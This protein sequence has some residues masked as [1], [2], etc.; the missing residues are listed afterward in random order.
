MTTMTLCREEESVLFDDM[1][2]WLE[3]DEDGPGFDTLTEKIVTCVNEEAESS[4]DEEKVGDATQPTIKASKVKDHLN[5]IN[6]YVG[7]YHENN[8]EFPNESV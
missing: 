2:A 3:T 6:Q 1:E 4:E 7:S 5:F 8:L